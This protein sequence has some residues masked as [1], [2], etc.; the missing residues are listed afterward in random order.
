M[1]GASNA[2]AVDLI[3]QWPQWPAPAVIVCGPAQSGKS[4]L[5]SVWRG[6]SKAV[7]IDA[8]DLDDRAIAMSLE[9]RAAVVEDIDRGI[10]S[11]RILFHLLN[12]VREHGT[13]LLLTSRLAPGDLAPALPDLRSRLRALPVARIAPPDDGLLQAV[14]VKLFSDRQ[15]QL[16]PHVVAYIVRH[17]ERSMASAV[18][19]AGALDT[20]A[21][22][23]RRRVTRALAA[24]VLRQQGSA[25]DEQDGAVVPITNR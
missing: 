13:S 20:M 21:L 25:L 22:A 19:I 3:D 16:E 18:A 15:L 24:D 4:H 9:A 8:A 5:A 7:R 23:A 2:A 10:A 17:M 14:L 6:R 11:E 1:V 12:L